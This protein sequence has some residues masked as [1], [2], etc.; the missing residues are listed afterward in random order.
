MTQLVH[1]LL[2]Q[3]QH[4][5]GHTIQNRCNTNFE[6]PVLAL[7]GVPDCDPAFMGT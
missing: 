1:S 2:E 6:P 4:D 3:R 7:G 5:E